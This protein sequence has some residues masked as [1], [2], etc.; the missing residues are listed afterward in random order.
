MFTKDYERV[1][2]K[3]GKVIKK[4]KIDSDVMVVEFEG[5]SARLVGMGIEEP[6]TY[7]AFTGFRA[8]GGVCIHGH[9]LDKLFSLSTVEEMD[10][11]ESEHNWCIA[12]NAKSPDQ[13]KFYYIDTNGFSSSIKEGSNMDERDVAICF[14]ETEKI[15]VLITISP[16]PI[17]QTAGISILIASKDSQ[18]SSLRKTAFSFLS[19]MNCEVIREL[20]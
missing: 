4:T 5:K 18:R 9:F 1:N 7:F 10:F 11:F 12:I 19:L 17:N 2:E 15:A 3:V 13:K 20:K 14:V 8:K 16:T 6:S